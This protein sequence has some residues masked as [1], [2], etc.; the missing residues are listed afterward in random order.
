MMT[1]ARHAASNDVGNRGRLLH[2][3]GRLVRSLESFAAQHGDQ[4]EV[5][6]V[7]EK[8]TRPLLELERQAIDAGIA[9]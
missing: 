9:A 5:L 4:D 2:S 3:A 1:H 6:A 8:W 7:F